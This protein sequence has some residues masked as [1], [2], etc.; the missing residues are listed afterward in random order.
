MLYAWLRFNFRQITS[1]PIFLIR[2]QDWC[3]ISRLKRNAFNVKL[4]F[5]YFNGHVPKGR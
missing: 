5:F 1:S 4:P 2:C 3:F